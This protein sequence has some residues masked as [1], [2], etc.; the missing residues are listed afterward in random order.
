[1]RL[2]I[3]DD[4]Y[5]SNEV[6]YGDVFAH[7]R[8]KEYAKIHDCL[9]VSFL[10]KADYVYEG[11]QV[12]AIREI[13]DLKKATDDFNPDIILIHFAMRNVIVDFV[14]KNTRKYIIWVHGYEA[15]GWYRRIFNMSIKDFYPKKLLLLAYFN[16]LQLRSFKSMIRE[17]NKTG[18]IHFV[19]VSNWMKKVASAD[20]FFSRIKYYSIIPNPI[21]DQLFKYVHKNAESRKN[22][23]LIRTFETRKYANDIAVEAIQYL[24]KYPCFHELTFS[25]Y[26]KG[27]YFTPLTD[28]IKE[29][30]NVGIFN[31]FVPQREIPAIHANSG[32]FLCPTRQDAQGVS[33]CEAMSSGLVPLTSNN[34]A[35]PEFV[36]N[37]INGFA[38][39]N[40]QE[41]AD[42]I[43]FLFDHPLEF[44]KMSERAALDVRGK[45][46]IIKVVDE[47]LELIR[48]CCRRSIL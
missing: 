8:V 40:S 31:K 7:V 45:A 33:M 20:T 36:N 25:I 35:I 11:I 34:T 17:S 13:E 43:Q 38:T 10:H 22:I 44:L 15:L 41:I 18:R 39:N 12:K 48:E 23:L 3:L 26:G 27:K 32:I 14:L 2:L 19:F 9:V 42:R 47:E 28:K 16:F 29:F 6:I 4:G 46:S 21:D 30:S 24:S 1:M 5:P 37:G